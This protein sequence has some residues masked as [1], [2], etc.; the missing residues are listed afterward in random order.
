MTATG[1]ASPEGPRRGQAPTPRAADPA[2]VH[3]DRADCGGPCDPRLA[4]IMTSL[5]VRGDERLDAAI[6][7]TDITDPG[8]PR[9]LPTPTAR[10]PLW[11]S[12]VHTL[13][14]LGYTLTPGHR[15]AV[16]VDRSL[17]A[18]TGELLRAP[19]M[20]VF[21]VGL[22]LSMAAPRHQRREA[23]WEA[24]NGRAAGPEAAACWTSG[25]GR[26]PWRRPGRS[27]RHRAKKPRARRHRE[28]RAGRW[29]RAGDAGGPLAGAVAT[30]D[31][32]AQLWVEPD[33][34]PRTPPA[35]SSCAHAPSRR[36]RWCRSPT[37]G[38]R[39]A[40]A[41]SPSRILAMRLDTGAPIPDAAITVLDASDALWRGRTGVDGLVIARRADSARS[42][43][44][45]AVVL[46]EKDGDASFVGRVRLAAAARQGPGRHRDVGPW[47][48][49]PGE[50]VE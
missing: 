16:R 19:W 44:T 35:V 41:A 38:C 18:Y 21:D 50:T 15:Y 22:P 48:V 9:P 34:K 6:A 28:Y 3:G 11:Q 20:S 49:R 23:V 8:A 24:A 5:P 42:D 32:F 17:A 7:L 10:T 46:A 40:A 1:V 13:Y 2:V 14:G 47:R 30:G 27:R 25:P 36:R 12:S 31:R 45:A 4:A 37:S 26:R 39:C 29:L 33:A 43:R